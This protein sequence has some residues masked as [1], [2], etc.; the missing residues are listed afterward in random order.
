M[1]VHPATDSTTM[2]SLGRR[3]ALRLGA[4]AIGVAVLG[5]PAQV[6]AAA[7]TRRLDLYAVNTGERLR[8]EYTVAGRY[9]TDALDAVSRLMRDHR[10]GDVHPIDPALL[11]ALH[12]I[13]R[14]LGVSRP[15]HVVCGYRSPE[16]NRRKLAAG[17]RVARNSYHL[18]GR[19]V[20]VV[21]PGRSPALVR[22][23]AMSLRAGG[24]G[25][26]PRSGFVH[27]DTGPVRTW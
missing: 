26:Y 25:Y 16:T 5:A 4:T 6:L 11:D 8:A 9:Q 10:T 20:D 2:R 14:R 17:Q 19:A 21:V 13:S 1:D 3:D 23:A 15:V 24:V 7:T 12:A 22:R 18:T 27:L